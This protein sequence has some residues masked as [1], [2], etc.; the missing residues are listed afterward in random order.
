MLVKSRTSKTQTTLNTKHVYSPTLIYIIISN[1]ITQHIFCYCT[2]PLCFIFA[3]TLMLYPAGV[4][5]IERRHL[6]RLPGVKL[7]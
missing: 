5:T 3:W 7:Q 4:G 2:F 1:F 6:T